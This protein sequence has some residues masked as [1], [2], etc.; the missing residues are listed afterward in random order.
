MKVGIT[1]P[2]VISLLCI[3]KTTGEASTDQQKLGSAGKVT[4][5]PDNVALLPNP[6]RQMSLIVLAQPPS[7]SS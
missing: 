5:R 3:G 7:R 6:S 2:V 4:L 1:C